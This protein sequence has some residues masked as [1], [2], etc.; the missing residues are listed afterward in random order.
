MKRDR[1]KDEDE[2]LRRRRAP[3]HAGRNG[4]RISTPASRKATAMPRSSRRR[5]ATSRARKA[6]RASLGAG[7]SREVSTRR[8]GERAR[9]R[10]R[11]QGRAYARTQAACG[12]RMT[13]LRS[14][15]R[16]PRAISTRISPPLDAALRAAP[17]SQPSIVDWDDASIDWSRFDLAVLRSTW[18]Y[19]QRLPEFLRWVDRVVAATTLLNPRDVVRWN[20]DKH[21]LAHLANAGVPIVPS[22]FVEPGDDARARARRVSR[23]ASAANSSSSRASARARAMRS[24]TRASE[25]DAALA[26]AQRLLDA[27]R[28]VLLQPYLDRVDEHGETALIFFD[29]AFSHAIRKGPL[30]RRGEGPTRA[31]FAAEHI[32]PRAP[33]A[34]EIA[35]R[36]AHARGDSVRAAAAVCARRPDPRRRRRAARA[37]ARTD[38]TVAVLR[39]RAGFGRAF[40]GCDL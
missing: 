38:R 8:V 9:F 34:D 12:S 22:T 23:S 14:S 35:R 39:A 24:A 5:S 30:L 29:G 3:A 20:T 13:R 6:C 2:T 33:S 11:T 36:R 1:G 7:L 21:Y 4:A 19:T 10:D 16:P 17:A 25:R 18:D 28:S 27:S 32:T 40:R 31:L 15:P 26:H 37:R